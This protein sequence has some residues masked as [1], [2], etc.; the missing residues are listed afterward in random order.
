MRENLGFRAVQ[1]E[2]CHPPG[3]GAAPE[4]GKPEQEQE[5]EQELVGWPF[6]EAG[7]AKLMERQIYLEM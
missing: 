1:S 7:R 3:V 6:G 2:D 5:Q 4:R